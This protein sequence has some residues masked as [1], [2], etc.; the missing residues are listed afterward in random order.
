M[1][2][3]VCSLILLFF[4]MQEGTFVHE[5]VEGDNVYNEDGFPVGG[6]GIMIKK[7]KVR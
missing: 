5:S 4:F 1:C 2:V 7:D 6:G 3:C